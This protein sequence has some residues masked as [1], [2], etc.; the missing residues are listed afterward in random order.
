MTYD[1]NVPP[2]D[3][4]PSV[5]QPIIQNNFKQLNDIFNENH[6][7]FNAADNR[8]K[9]RYSSY[10]EQSAD[11]STTATEGAVYTKDVSG[12]S[13]LFYRYKSSGDVSQLTWIKAWVR[14]G[15]A[16][17]TIFDSYNVSTVVRVFPNYVITFATPLGNTNYLI[18]ITTKNQRYAPQ[19]RTI[20]D[21][22][23]NGQ[24]SDPDVNV[25][26]IGT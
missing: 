9:H 17:P 24:F 2:A 10:V 4:R 1:P 20:N 21:C 23:I 12:R 18:L 3:Q 26:I 22:T 11:P 25:L 8:G 16:T 13:E 14:F 7:R 6:F 5:S 15:G 19:A